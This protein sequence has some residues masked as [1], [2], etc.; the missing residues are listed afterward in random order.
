MVC[1]LFSAELFLPLLV[2]QLQAHHQ[3]FHEESDLRGV[4]ILRRQ[5]RREPEGAAFFPEDVG[6]SINL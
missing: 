4:E 2:G 5:A 6:T 1:R 3:E